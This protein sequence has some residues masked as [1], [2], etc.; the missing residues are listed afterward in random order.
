MAGAYREQIVESEACR[1]ARE[2]KRYLRRWGLR[3]SFPFVVVW[4]LFAL[5]FGLLI[6]SLAGV[7]SVIG[8]GLLAAGIL[9]LVIAVFAKLARIRFCPRCGLAIPL[10]NVL[11]RGPVACTNCMLD[12]GELPSANDVGGNSRDSGA[13]EETALARHR[14]RQ[15]RELAKYLRAWD[16][17]RWRRL[18][19]TLLVAPL[20]VMVLVPFFHASRTVA[21]VLFSLSSVLH[22]AAFPLLVAWS[23]CPRCGRQFQDSRCRFCGLPWGYLPI[24][25][26]TPDAGTSGTE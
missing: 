3:R 7:E 20:A 19:G 2:R 16:R 23:A 8:I 10:P 6:A 12:E 13:T 5:V 1:F 26:E 24:A 4:A 18:L 22:V 14:G 9:C 25:T 15:A 11:G 21:I 17:M